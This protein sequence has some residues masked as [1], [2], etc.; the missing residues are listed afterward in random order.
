LP[1]NTSTEY[2]TV[3]LQDRLRRHQCKTNDRQTSHSRRRGHT[4][5]HLPLHIYG[6]NEYLQIDNTVTLYSFKCQSL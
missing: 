5:L 4:H 1:G 2:I 6:S 3:G